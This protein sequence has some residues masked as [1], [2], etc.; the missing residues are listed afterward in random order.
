[1][2]IIPC[3]PCNRFYVT[4]KLYKYLVKL[5]L[6]EICSNEYYPLYGYTH[7]LLLVQCHHYRPV[8]APPPPPP[9]VG[10]VSTHTVQRSTYTEVIHRVI[11][12]EVSL[13]Q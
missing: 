3:I 9:V 10:V 2:R 1:M 13:V 6:Y 8:V 12:R 5:D 4:L 11:L 7:K